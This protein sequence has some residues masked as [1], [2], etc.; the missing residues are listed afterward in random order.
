VLALLIKASLFSDLHELAVVQLQQGVPFP[1]LIDH[2]VD[3]LVLEADRVQSLA[4]RVHA[5]GI[6]G[7][8]ELELMR[9]LLQYS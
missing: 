8:R 7:A 6:C 3:M 2:G 5:G 9:T 4:Y 1:G